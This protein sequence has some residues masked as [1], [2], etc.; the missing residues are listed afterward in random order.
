MMPLEE[1]TQLPESATPYLFVH[2][3]QM[4]VT[5]HPEIPAHTWDGERWVMIVPIAS[6]PLYYHSNWMHHA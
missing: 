4:V 1:D 2:F 3:R 5:M 6:S